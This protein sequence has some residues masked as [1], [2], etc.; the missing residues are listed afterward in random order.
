MHVHANVFCILLLVGAGITSQAQTDGELNRDSVVGWRYVSNPPNPKAVYKPVK[1][2][3]A[4]GASYT[5]WQQQA[6]DL[7]ASWIQQSYQPRGLVIR[8][9]VKN[10]QRWNL[11]DNGPIHSYGINLLGYSSHFV[12]GKIDL[13]CCEV[14]TRMIAGF[15]DFPGTYVIGFN[16]G[17][18]YFFAEHAQF[19]AGEDD[20]KLAAE[21]V[22][23]R[24]QPNLYGYRTYLDHYHDG[25]APFN[26]IEIVVPKN[27]EWPFKPVLVKDAIAYIQQQMAAYPGILQ[28]N[29]YSADPIQKA[30]ERLKPYY[31]E[32]AKLNPNSN[33]YNAVNDG[34]GHYILNPEAIINGKNADKTFPEYNVLVSTTQQVIS[35]SASDN[36]LWVYFNFSPPTGVALKG[37]PAQFDP[38]LGTDVAHMVYS[39]LHNF[40]FDYASRWVADPAK[41]KNMPYAPL[42][43]PA[44]SSGATTAGPVTVS[45]TTA[46]KNKDPYT[47]VYEDFDGYPAGTLSARSW[48]TYGHDGHSFENATLSTISGQPGKWVGIPDAFTFYPDF[49]KVLGNN[50]TVNYDVYFGKDVKNQRSPIYFR[51]DTYDPNPKKSNPINLNDINR[52]G[53]QFALAMS[54]ELEGNK[55]YM[56]AKQ[57][58]VVT[59]ARIAAFKATDVAHVTITVSGASVVVSVN[60][61]EVMRDNNALPAGKTFRRYGWYCGAPGVNLGMIY[62]RNGSPVQE[63][64]GKE[65]QVA[66]VIKDNTPGNATTFET[67]DYTLAPLQ[68]LETLPPLNYPA[69]FKSSLPV[70]QPVSTG[71]GA[72]ASLPA[73]KAPARSALLNTLPKTTDNSGFKKLIDDLAALVAVKLNADNVKK[74]DAYLKM[75]KI[76][77]SAALADE[78][79]GVWLQGKPTVALYLF[80]KALQADYGNLNA[81]NNLASLLNTYGYSEKAIPI[82]QF[83]DNKI[84]NNPQVLANMATAFYNLGDVDNALLFAN[85][86]IDKD[87]VSAIANKVAAFVHLDKAVESSNKAEAEKAI[88]CL[89]Q[90]LKSGYDKESADI[91]NKIERNHQQQGD[92]SNTNFKEFPML[93]RLELPKMP[94]DL[95]QMIS[96][97]NYLELEKKAINTAKEQVFAAEKKIPPVDVKQSVASM[98]QNPAEATMMM[99]AASIYTTGVPWYMKMKKDLKDIF[100]QD[101]DAL[102]KK[103]N[104]QANAVL[105]TY[106]DR[107]AKLEGGEGNGAE[108][109]EMEQLKIQRCE[110]FNKE[111]ASY[112]SDVA[113]LTNEFAQRS[114]YVSR[115]Y[116]RDVANWGPLWKHDYTMRSFL[117]AQRTYLTD[118]YKILSLYKAIEPC[119]YP[120]EEQK[121]DNKPSKPKE[122]EEQYCANF[123]GSAGAGPVKMNWTCNSLSISGGEGFVGEA[124]LNFSEAGAFKDVTLGAGIGVEMTVGSQQ[125]TG[126]S[127]SASMME[128]VNIGPAAGG[129]IQVNDWGISAGVGAGGNIGPVSGEVNIASTTMSVNGGVTAGGV[130]AN[131]LGINKP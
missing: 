129:G 73:F 95:H 26:K 88:G 107:L 105:K 119:I 64:P 32:I 87:S 23:K 77:S 35:Q 79:I 110:A 103:H 3:Y 118:M 113:K 98:R 120:P 48:H 59:S 30:I 121:R 52:E 57:D 96:F 100:K 80:C 106:N 4:N 94:E 115:I 44:T 21:G 76:S 47:I 61:K 7:I 68:K 40:N 114:E 111:Q 75:K 85:K 43:A 117:E 45:S 66:G 27:G 5:A 11:S 28:K 42:Q 56:S 29:P 126:I 83:L 58:E 131:A 97:D 89:K 112:L 67:S 82:L 22:D 24:I 50:F 104:T 2:T 19:S 1:S 6:S 20:A 90:A 18:L 16:P 70:A 124:A 12:G 125:V 122:W 55:R 14:G 108:E 63:L 31:N 9:I 17:G 13:K 8:Q 92:Y 62:V 116:C 130:V 49:N 74:I 72:V 54:G 99:K 65:P 10:D 127:A 39:M 51:L 102:T 78:A 33:Y 60:G 25:G 34:N 128:F 37:N 81:A 38:K 101:L 69:G 46:A 91:L 71:N 93:R 109:E 84:K 36:P 41:M 53:F 86:S 123:K 15:N